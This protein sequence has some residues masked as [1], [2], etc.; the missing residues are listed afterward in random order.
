MPKL[1]VI[2]KKLGL[3]QK[4]LADV[5]GTVQANISSYERGRS[6]PEGRVRQLI[7]FAATR[8][9]VLSYDHIYGQRPFP[10]DVELSHESSDA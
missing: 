9:I 1:R 5:L 2:R 8:G 7:E 10:E 4:A 3:S 6:I